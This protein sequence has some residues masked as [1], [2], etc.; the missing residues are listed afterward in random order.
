[1]ANTEKLQITVTSTGDGITGKWEPTAMTNSA[2]VAGGPVK[3][4]LASGDNSIAVP[5]GAMGM[6]LAPPASSAVVLRLK[7]YAGETG[8]ALRSGQ[9]SAVPLP[10]GTSSVMLNASATEIVY[11][12]WT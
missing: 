12:H 5:T 1:M 7:H 10:T 2:G 8:F 6:V 3:T 11:V 9:P 4:T